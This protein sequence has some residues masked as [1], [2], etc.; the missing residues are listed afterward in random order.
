MA[1]VPIALA[2][3]GAIS[4][5]NRARAQKRAQEEQNKAAAEQTM[6][7]PWTG[8][9][10]GQANY[11]ATPGALDQ[12]VGGAMQGYMMGSMF[13]QANAPKTGATDA[14]GGTTPNTADAAKND[15][16]QDYGTSMGGAMNQRRK[17]TFFGNNGSGSVF[18]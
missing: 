4:G 11:S 10:A 13:N 8:M 16:G 15:L 7:S 2:A 6:Y 3:Y 18:G 1:W 17:P 5:A 14:S 12:G 9:G